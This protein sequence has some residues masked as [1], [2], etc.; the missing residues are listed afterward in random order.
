ML[1]NGNEKV[2]H[3]TSNITSGGSQD[4]SNAA[5]EI[6]M[7]TELR[8]PFEV[9]DIPA[10]LE[11]GPYKDYF[12]QGELHLVGTCHVGYNTAELVRETISR[13]R[14][15][16]VLVELDRQRQSILDASVFADFT[17]RHLPAFSYA[18][19]MRTANETA[20]TIP[21]CQVILGDR[22]FTT[23]LKRCM[24]ALI[25]SV[26]LL[27]ILAWSG[28]VMFALLIAPLAGLFVESADGR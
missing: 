21:N 27:Q 5:M 15:D 4:D 16:V 7:V 20:R 12:T 25:R 11:C 8:V 14:P 2:T 1:H 3:K 10:E 23:T 24:M 28:V 22:N 6:D 26:S 19:D 9:S 13:L 17:D 18:R